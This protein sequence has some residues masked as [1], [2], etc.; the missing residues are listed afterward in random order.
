MDAAERPTAATTTT[1]TR[2]ISA[3]DLPV[4]AVR[5]VTIAGRPFCLVHAED[6]RFYAVSDR[7]SHEGSPLSEGWAS[8]IEIECPRHNAMFDLQ[9]GEATSLPA[10]EPIETHPVVVRGDDVF[11]QVSVGSTTL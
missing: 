9:T 10:T 5:R 8:G 2:V 6:D 4:G 3:A 11:V 7:C 1:E